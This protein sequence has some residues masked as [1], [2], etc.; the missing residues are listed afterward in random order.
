MHTRK[1][2]AALLGVD[3]T[4]ASDSILEEIEQDA[5]KAAKELKKK[6]AKLQAPSII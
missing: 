3:W 5:L 2:A 4:P 1:G 6:F